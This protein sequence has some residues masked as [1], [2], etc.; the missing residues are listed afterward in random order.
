MLL[1]KV[2]R[3]HSSS[4]AG[5]LHLFAISA[6]ASQNCSNVSLSLCFLF[7]NLCLSNV[8]FVFLTNAIDRFSQNSLKEICRILA[9]VNFRPN[10]FFP[11]FPR[12]K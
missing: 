8:T 12:A 1:I 7:K 2:S 5:I 10:V 11:S 3:I 9:F 4:P 6:R